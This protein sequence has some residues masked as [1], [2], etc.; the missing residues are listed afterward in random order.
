MDKWLKKFPG[1]K[2][3]IENTATNASAAN[4]K[5]NSRDDA[6]HTPKTSCSSFIMQ[7]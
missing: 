6:S 3:Q 1:N 7:D 2:L 5:K 4:Y